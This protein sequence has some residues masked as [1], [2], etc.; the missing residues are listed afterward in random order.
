MLLTKWLTKVEVKSQNSKVK[1]KKGV[2]G[3]EY[4]CVACPKDLPQSAQ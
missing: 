3:W 4:T 2:L 1:I